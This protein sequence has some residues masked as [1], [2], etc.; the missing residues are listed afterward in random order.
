MHALTHQPKRR[1][2]YT[3]LNEI[4]FPQSDTEFEVQ[5]VLYCRLK[6]CG[7][8]VRGEVFCWCEDRGMPARTRLDLVVFNDQLQPVVIIECKNRNGNAE[9]VFTLTSGTRQHRR[10]HKFGLPVVQCPSMGCVEQ[11]KDLVMQHLDHETV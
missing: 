1:P 7:L 3:T 6:Q 11:A 4:V 5:A 10:Y 8:N 9:P 2:K